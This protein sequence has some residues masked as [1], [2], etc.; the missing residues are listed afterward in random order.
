MSDPDNE[1]LF[2][3]SFATMQ[4]KAH[5][6]SR[7]KGFWENVRNMGESVALVHSELSELLEGLRQ[8]NPPSDKIPEFTQAEEEAADVII[9]LFDMAGGAGWNLAGAV[10]AKMK[11]N[12][13]RPHKHGKQF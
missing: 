5:Q 13:N 2:L 8:G 7:A 4:E 1:S 11:Y 12:A 10:V 6:N 9:R 3:T